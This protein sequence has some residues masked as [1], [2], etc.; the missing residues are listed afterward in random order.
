M[1]MVKICGITNEDDLEAAVS[2]G[3]DSL[4]FVVGVALITAEPYPFPK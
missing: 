2:S 4:G 3:A 1:L